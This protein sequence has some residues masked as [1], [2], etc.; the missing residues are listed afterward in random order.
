MKFWNDFRE[1][2]YYLFVQERAVMLQGA[3]SLGFL[4]L[5]TFILWRF[6][7]PLVGVAFILW[8]LVQL[9]ARSR[10]RY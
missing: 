2:L 7:H 10:S 4:A 8:V 5:V 3:L 1:A 6:V 9:A